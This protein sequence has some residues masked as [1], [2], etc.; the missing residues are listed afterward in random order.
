MGQARSKLEDVKRELALLEAK[1]DTVQI[2]QRLSLLVRLALTQGNLEDALAKLD[3]ILDIQLANSDHATKLETA[4]TMYFIG[5][6]LRLL[7]LRNSSRGSSPSEGGME[8]RA[9]MFARAEAMLHKSLEIRL[10]HK[11]ELNRLALVS[12][13]RAMLALLLQQQNHPLQARK[14]HEDALEGFCQLPL[15]SDVQMWTFSPKQQQWTSKAPP[16]AETVLASTSQRHLSAS[17]S[18]NPPPR[19]TSSIILNP[20]RH[21]RNSM[22]QILFPNSRSTHQLLLEASSQKANELPSSSRRRSETSPELYRANSLLFKGVGVRASTAP[23]SPQPK[24]SW[25]LVLRSSSLVA[26]DQRRGGGFR[27]FSG[28]NTPVAAATADSEGNLLRIIDLEPGKQISLGLSLPIAAATTTAMGSAQIYIPLAPKSDRFGS[29]LEERHCTLHEEVG[30]GDDFGAQ[31][32]EDSLHQQQQQR[33]VIT[34]TVRGKA[35][36]KKGVIVN[37]VRISTSPLRVGDVI[38]IGNCGKI[39]LGQFAP[40]KQREEDFFGLEYEV[41]RIV[42]AVDSGDVNSLAP[43][44]LFPGEDAAYQYF[45]VCCVAAQVNLN[46]QPLRDEYIQEMFSTAVK[47]GIPYY[48]WDSFVFAELARARLLL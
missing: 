40:N 16:A 13:T 39:K 41:Q 35:G 14:M 28:G 2:I 37:R 31:G 47:S 36:K 19:P 10:A 12:K 32:E 29:F 48:Q 43:P 11:D 38:Q 22:S 25:R 1:G 8:A 5:N 33:W 42:S 17:S 7:L 6:T 45:H 27:R 46:G 34:D 21:S 26:G 3:T 44:K 9:E 30:D 15:Q 24:P 20:I 23:L 4:Q 18:L